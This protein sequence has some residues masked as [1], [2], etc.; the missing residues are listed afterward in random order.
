M[1][2]TELVRL[3]KDNPTEY[4]RMN[5]CKLDVKLWAISHGVPVPKLYWA[6]MSNNIPNWLPEQ[7]VLK[8]NI[9]HSSRQVYV[10]PKIEDVHFSRPEMVIIEEYIPTGHIDYK[11]WM[12]HGQV[13]TIQVIERSSHRM[14]FYN[15]LWEPGLVTRKNISLDEK[16]PKPKSLE[17]MIHIAKKLSC[18]YPFFVRIDLFDG[19]YFC[20]LTY[21]PNGLY[22][23]D[24][25]ADV[26]IGKIITA[27]APICTS[28][29]I[30][31]L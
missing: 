20:E 28:R 21:Q 1:K 7:F 4:H 17:D 26:A 14:R 10:N 23:I 11:F 25:K 13:I 16:R 24:S 15:E 19:P 31:F 6:G 5:D 2:F 29:L 22:N 8:P 12:F 30:R 18:V 9:G 3:W 27:G